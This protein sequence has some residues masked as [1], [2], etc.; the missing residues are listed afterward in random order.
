V[1]IRQID[2]AYFGHGPLV[3]PAGWDGGA[4]LI[5]ELDPSQ[6]KCCGFLVI[7]PAD[8]VAVLIEE[9]DALFGSRLRT[10]FEIALI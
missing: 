10:C 1:Q 6:G 7:F 4:Q 5:N 8:P 3:F 2:I 9:W